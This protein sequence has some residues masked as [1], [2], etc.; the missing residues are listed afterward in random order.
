MRVA[1]TGAT[2]LVG[3]NLVAALNQAGHTVRATRRASSDIST[4]EDMKVEWAEADLDDET[5][6]AAAFEGA[7]LVFHCAAAV[8]IKRKIEPWIFDANVTGT[9]NVIEACRKAGVRRLLHCSSTVT[10]GVGRNGEPVNEESL[11]NL[12]TVGLDDAYATTKRQ[13]EELVLAAVAAGLDAVIVNPGYMFGPYD[14]HPSS[15]KLLLEVVRRAVPGYSAGRNSFVDVRDVASGMISAAD[16]G[17]CGERYI[18]GGHNLFYGELFA[19]VAQVAGTRPITLAMPRWLASIPALFGDLQETFAGKE[20]LLNSNTIAWAYEPNFIVSSEKARRELGYAPRPIEDGIS[21][22][23]T[24][25]RQA[26][27]VGPLPNFP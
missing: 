6:L 13:A 27:M 3:A 12:E 24:W 10:V 15:G 8:T 5:A 2:G 17:A 26:G 18:L 1:V 19:R 21:A 11:W 14:S 20:P 22:A 25:F 16:R 23:L 7:E 4:L 9:R